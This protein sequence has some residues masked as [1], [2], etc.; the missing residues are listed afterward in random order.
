MI[1]SRINRII[2]SINLILE[3]LDRFGKNDLVWKKYIFIF[4]RN[5]VS[6]EITSII[7]ILSINLILELFDR[8]NLVWKKLN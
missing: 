2:F 4:L 6:H 7:I 5:N 1:Y 3:L 8:F